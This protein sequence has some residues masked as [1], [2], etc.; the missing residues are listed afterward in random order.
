MADWVCKG[1]A[2]AQFTVVVI[3]L[4]NLALY[5]QKICHQRRCRSGSSW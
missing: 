2:Q 1:W 4:V 5:F 3:L